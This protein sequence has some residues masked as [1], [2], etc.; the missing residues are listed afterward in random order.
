MTELVSRFAELYSFPLDDYQVAGCRALADGAGVLVAAPTGAGKTVVGEFAVWLALETGRKCFYTTPIKALSNQKFHDLVARHGADAVGLLTGDASVNGDAPIVVMTTEVLRNM[1]YAGSTG[2]TNLGFVVMDEVHYLADRFRGAV[3]EEVILGL[4]PSVQIAALSATVSNVEDFGEWLATV[5]GRFE[6]VVSERRPV[7]LYQH[8]LVGSKLVDLFDGVAPTAMERPADR[9]AKVNKELLKVSKAEASRVRDDSRR[10]RGRSGRG[11]KGRGPGSFGGDVHP[12]FAGKPTSRADLARLLERSRLLPAICFIFSRAGCDAAVAQLLAAGVT[13]TSR[14]EAAL[15]GEIADRH[16]AGLSLHDLDALGY[17]DFRAAFTAGIAAHHAGQL[18]AFKAIVEEGFATGACKL[19]FATETLALGINMPART[20]VLEK[21]V[22]YNGEAVVD[23]TPGE[24]TQLT[25]RAGRRGIDV[26]GHAVVLWQAG[27]DPRAVAGLA[28]KRTYPLRSSFAPSYNMAVNLT[29]TL[30][31]ERAREVLNQ[32]FAQFTVDKNVVK[33]ARS[34]K[35]LT[36]EIAQLREEADCHLGDFMSYAQLRDEVSQL[37]STSAAARRARRADDIA[38]AIATLMPGDIIHVPRQG[39]CVVLGIGQKRSRDSVPW[40][41]V[42]AVDHTVLRLQPHDLPGAPVPVGRIRVPR[43]FSLQDRKSRRELLASLSDK[44]ESLDPEVPTVEPT[45]TDEA[46]KARIAEL[47]SE[48]KRHPCHPCEEREVHA[49]AAA[50]AIRLEREQ[51]RQE[52]AITGR[53]NSLGVQFDRVC[54]VLTELGY[55]DGDDLTDA[56]RM[57]RRIYNEL[58][59]VAAECIRRDVFAGLDAPQLAAVLSSLLY[60][61][62][63]SREARRPRMPDAASEAAQSALRGVWR[64]VGALERNHRLERGREPDIGFAEA[65]WRWCSG[66]ELS[67][68][69]LHSGLPAGDFVRWVRQV[70]DLAGQLATAV[71]PGDLRRTC[72]E[73]VA[74]MRRGVVDTDIEED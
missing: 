19:V 42:I 45:L 13:L 6:V 43:R 7:P 15:L 35:D 39:W 1:I 18:P 71:G 37:E 51:A 38:E 3:W 41:Q 10:P 5:R 20:V 56:G 59:L 22:K 46:H 29:A 62:R 14:D 55:L 31:R 32:S 48:L 68:V 36:R 53:T 21:L 27:M 52:A 40:V 74:A 50:R 66:Q 34:G 73:I 2:L 26:E 72:R 28:S 64:E 60:E 61:S 49:V 65:A 23:I 9:I 69:L 25:G 44:L 47:R 54:G 11:K 8:V 30:G 63:P 67:K 33:A 70:V 4:A 16:V 17:E 57:L 58:D 24:Y 12:R